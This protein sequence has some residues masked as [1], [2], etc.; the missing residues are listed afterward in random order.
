MMVLCG[1]TRKIHFEKNVALARK[2]DIDLKGKLCFFQ[3]LGM[4]STR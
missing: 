4:Q 3:G 2:K 1:F